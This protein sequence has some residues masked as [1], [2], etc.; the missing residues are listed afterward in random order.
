MTFRVDGNFYATQTARVGRRFAHA[1]IAD[2]LEG[3]TLL[4]DAFHMLGFSKLRTFRN[5]AWELGF[6]HGLPD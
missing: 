5:L 2:T 4:R 1:L 6:D 3:R